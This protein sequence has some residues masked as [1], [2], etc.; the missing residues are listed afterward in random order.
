MKKTYEK[1]FTYKVEQLIESL[2]YSVILRSDLNPLKSEGQ[3]TYALNKLIKQEKIARISYGIYAKTRP[4]VYIPDRSILRCSG[5]FSMLIR[6]TLD[7]LNIPWQQSEA[8]EQ[9]NLRISTQ[10]PV[11]SILRLKKDLTRKIAFKNM[12]FK[13]KKVA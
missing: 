13:Y 10:V 2:P 3:I 1:S 7:R 8:E 12:V 6:E 11:R 5:G 4:S 9:Y